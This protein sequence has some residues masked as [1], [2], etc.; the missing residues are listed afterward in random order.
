MRSILFLSLFIALIGCQNNLPDTFED[1][2]TNDLGLVRRSYNAYVDGLTTGDADT[3]KKYLYDGIESYFQKSTAYNFDINGFIRDSLA[4]PAK[5]A[6]VSFQSQ[7]LSLDYRVVEPIK[8]TVINDK[9]FYVLSSEI[10]VADSTGVKYRDTLKTLG[11]AEKNHIAFMNIGG[12]Y[13]NVLCGNFPFEKFIYGS[14]YEQEVR[15]RNLQL[16]KGQAWQLEAFGPDSDQLYEFSEDARNRLVIQDVGNLPEVIVPLGDASKAKITT[17]AQRQEIVPLT[18]THNTMDIKYKKELVP[19]QYRIISTG[20]DM[21]YLDLIF[22]YE[23]GSK[24]VF[25]Y[26]SF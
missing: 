6:Q 5:Q 14:R 26:V 23:P 25:S 15:Q 10:L 11:I 7:G 24:T 4:T 3:L 21:Y 8:N 16:L 13:F 20:A 18:V 9:A 17:I 2:S 12:T 19:A 22:K 1:N